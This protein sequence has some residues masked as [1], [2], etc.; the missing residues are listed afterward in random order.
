MPKQF[1][2][3][4]ELFGPENFDLKN[5]KKQYKK[6]A[7]RYHPDKDGEKELFQELND[8]YLL[9]LPLIKD[10][11]LSKEEITDIREVLSNSS[12][13]VRKEIS[14]QIRAIKPD[15]FSVRIDLVDI[16]VA[17]AIS[18]PIGALANGT[19]G[20]IGKYSLSFFS[21][22]MASTAGTFATFAGI[23]ALAYFLSAFPQVITQDFIE[24]SS[25]L[26]ENPRI[27]SFLKYTSSFLIELGSLTV[28]AAM[29]G[30]PI[31]TTLICSMVIPTAVYVFNTLKNTINFV[32]DMPQE[33][34]LALT[35]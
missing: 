10:G 29:L 19:S 21:P 34:R 9:L 11:Y 17:A 26:E 31:A 4:I 35:Y 25:F 20:I 23:G 3:I 28:A 33:K 24:D 6:A 32:E 14:K 27:R 30:T 2:R 7:L 22:A 13:T 5:L 8:Y 16:G 1:E 12:E 15:F 18:A